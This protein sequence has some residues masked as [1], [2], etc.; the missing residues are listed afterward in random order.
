[1]GEETES[2]TTSGN[3]SEGSAGAVGEAYSLIAP[4]RYR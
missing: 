3:R 1:M 4:L 2:E